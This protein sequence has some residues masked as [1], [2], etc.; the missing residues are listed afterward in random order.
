MAERQFVVM[1]RGMCDCCH[2]LGEVAKAVNDSQTDKFSHI[3]KGVCGKCKGE[4]V[5][6][7]EVLLREALDALAQED[8]RETL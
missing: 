6:L 8:W 7:V 4:G 5:V 1:E 2:G 3:Y